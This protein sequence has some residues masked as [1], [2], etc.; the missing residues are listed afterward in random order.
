M[1]YRF[2]CATCDAWHEGFPDMGFVA[3]DYAAD[4]PEAERVARLYLTSDFCVV[5]DE[6]FFIRCQLSLPIR[7]LDEKFGWGV[8]SSLSEANFM[9]YQEAYGQDMT[10][11]DPM[12]GYLAN[13]LPDYPNTLNLKLSVQPRAAG[14]R[15]TLMLEPTDHPL[16][17]EQRDG[18]ALESVLK[19]VQPFLAH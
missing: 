19:I 4:I 8:W 13:Q 10:D 2:K 12:F 9:R 17:I 16:A 6:H 5:E 7:G 11:W 1:P 18:V 3:P 15:P 14:L